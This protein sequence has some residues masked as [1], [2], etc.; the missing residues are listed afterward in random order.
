MP[1]KQALEEVTDCCHGL[2]EIWTRKELR[3][4]LQLTMHREELKAWVPEGDKLT[5][6][7]V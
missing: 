6:V 2:L 1:N 3:L 7:L 5:F 4:V